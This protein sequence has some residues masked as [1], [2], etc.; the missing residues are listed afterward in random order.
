MT[1]EIACGLCVL[2]VDAHF[3]F[4]PHGKAPAKL[5]RD[6]D[7]LRKLAAARIDYREND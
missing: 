7:P 2:N 4:C 1:S 5:A 6:A 3:G